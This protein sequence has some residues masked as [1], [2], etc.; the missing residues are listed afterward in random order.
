MSIPYRKMEEDGA[1]SDVSFI[2]K[3]SNSDTFTYCPHCNSFSYYSW[4]STFGEYLS[5]CSC[6]GYNNSKIFSREEVDL[7]YEWFILVKES[8]KSYRSNSNWYIAQIIP[9]NE[10][11][12]KAKIMEVDCSKYNQSILDKNAYK[13]LEELDVY[14]NFSL[15][16]QHPTEH[17]IE[18]IDGLYKGLIIDMTYI[19]WQYKN[20]F[21]KFNP[22]EKEL[23]ECIELLK[24]INESKNIEVKTETDNDLIPF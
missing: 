21:E 14:N 2:D 11:D 18:V 10:N 17:K 15:I 12:N 6:C 1:I 9:P 20:A 8:H 7:E 22:S 13:A 16:L 3:Y 4:E 24:R 5:S 23:E 19:C